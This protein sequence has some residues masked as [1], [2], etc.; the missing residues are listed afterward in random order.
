MS[1]YKLPFLDEI[2]NERSINIKFIKYD[3]IE[4]ITNIVVS[5]PS[6]HFYLR[7]SKEQINNNYKEWDVYKKFTNPYEFIHTNYDKKNYISTLKPLS[8]AYYKMIELINVFNH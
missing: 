1:Y 3:S 5:N 7:Q 2:I 8:R 6:L 4:D